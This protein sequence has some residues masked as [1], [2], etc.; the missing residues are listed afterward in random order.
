MKSIAQWSLRSRLLAAFLGVLI[1][2]LALTGVGVVG[3]WALWQSIESLRHEAV[4]EINGTTHLQLAV[5]QLVLPANHYLITGDP[6][7]REE[8]DQRLARVKQ[9]IAPVAS[10][11]HDPEERRLLE[12]VKGQVVRIEGLSRQL[13]ALSDPR[14]NPAALAEV[15]AMVQLADDT[16]E[17]LERIHA[18]AHREIEEDT[19]HASS[20]I[21]R[22]AV[23]GLL[24]LILSAAGA[25]GLALLLSAWLS[26]PLQALAQ[27]SRRIADEGDLSQRVEVHTGGEVGEATRAFNQMAEQLETSA[28]ERARLYKEAEKERQRLSILNDINAATSSTLALGKVMDVL[29]DKLDALLPYS[30]ATIRLLNRETGKL[31]PV[32]SRKMDEAEWKLYLDKTGGGLSQTVLEKKTPLVITNATKDPRMREPEF[33]RKLG[34][35]SYIGLPFLVKGEALGVLAFCTTEEHEFADE[36]V[37]FLET[38]AGQAA[39]AI[40]NSQLYEQTKKQA[41]ELEKARE[42]EADFAAM[43]AHDLR[44]PLTNVI[45]IAEMMK[46]DLLGPVNEDQK[47]WLGKITDDV[48]NLVNLVSDFLDLSKLEAG[49]IELTKKPVYIE[50][51]IENNLESYQLLGQD[52]KITF[53][54]SLDP[55]LPT[56]DADPRRLDQVLS[57]LLSNAVKFTPEGGHIEVGARAE[58]SRGVNFWVR[59]TGVGIPK[60]EIG[61]LFEKYKQASNAKNGSH[62]GTGLGLAICKMIVEI[63]GGRIWLDSEENKGTTVFVSLPVASGPQLRADPPPERQGYE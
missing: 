26:R 40:H 35:T 41:V 38:I 57:N 19:E 49:H 8:F 25:A 56:V 48:R 51:L 31:E 3:F 11:F 29:L 5:T 42:L 54:S 2:Y 61:N 34:L 20:M 10:A 22:L 44:S 62:N 18:V 52:K 55:Y 14:N 45:G 39:L 47:K 15:T 13:F 16:V 59:D 17:V 1:P 27:A 23:A 58:D 24:A 46:D 36:E 7:E 32:A 30:A 21:R 9:S 37:N 28:R 50:E 12:I 60:E 6:R 43:I 53:T 63:H 33:F 4:A